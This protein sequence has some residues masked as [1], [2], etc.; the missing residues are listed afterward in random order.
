MMAATPDSMSSLEGFIDGIMERSIVTGETVGATVALVGNGRLLVARGYGM[1]DIELGIPVD[2]RVTAFR[3]GSIS[4]VFVWMSVLQLVEAGKLDLD[5]DINTY[6][7]DFELPG[8]FTDPITM[9]HLMTHTPGFEES[10]INLFVSGPR[11]LGSLAQTLIRDLPR[12]VRFP[13]RLVSYSNYGA[14]LAGHVV[15]RITGQSWDDYVE[16]HIFQPLSMDGATMRQPC[17][18]VSTRRVPRVMSAMA[19]NLLSKV[20]CMCR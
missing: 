16:T 8:E 4:K 2:S 14:A 20:L 5:A 9:R 19:T 7:T 17:R 10:L 6:L 18:S 15:A 3:I 11:Q 1:A 12:R 13:G